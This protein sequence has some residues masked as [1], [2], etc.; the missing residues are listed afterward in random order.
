MRIGCIPIAPATPVLLDL[1]GVG[2]RVAALGKEAREVL[3]GSGGAVSE[4][5]VITVVG[6][7]GASHCKD[8]KEDVLV[9]CCLLPIGQERESG[10]KVGVIKGGAFADWRVTCWAVQVMSTAIAWVGVGDSVT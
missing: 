9:G 2:V 8:G 1:L 5:L 3:R 4:T 10:R 6:L 7:V